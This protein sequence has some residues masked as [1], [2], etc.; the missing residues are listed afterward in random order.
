MKFS[1]KWLFMI[2]IG[3]ILFSSF[4]QSTQGVVF[5]TDFMPHLAEGNSEE[6]VLIYKYDTI[7]NNRIIFEELKSRRC[8][9]TPT[10]FQTA[11]SEDT[12][13]ISW[14]FTYEGRA[15]SSNKTDLI[16]FNSRSYVFIAAE[17]RT[18][19]NLS[20]FAT[21]SEDNGETWNDI[22]WVFNS[23][24]DI[25]YFIEFGAANLATDLF[26]AYSYKI[27]P[28]GSV[29]R[30]EILTIDP[31]SLEVETADVSTDYYGDDFDLLTHE[32]VIY[33]VSTYE[34]FFTER[35]VRVTSTTT[36]TSLPGS[37][38]YLMSPYNLVDFF[39]PAIVAWNDG[40]FIVAHDLIED[41]FDEI[42]N[43]TFTEHILWGA[44]V[45]NLADPN[46]ITYHN[47]VKEEAE[48]Y[49]RK[50]PSLSTYEGQ[51][52]L[53]FEL[54]E[55]TKLGGGRPEVAFSFSTNGNKWTD[56]FMGDFKIYFNPG[57]FFAIATVACFAIV[58]PVYVI[59]SKT[60]KK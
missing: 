50:S 23:S 13:I 26:I 35:S 7:S 28:A 46:T 8:R 14:D 18:S 11:E 34:D 31:I 38:A 22:K 2:L 1:K 20:F 12:L 24:I 56:N 19:G 21:F 5:Y 53:A 39:E 33:V 43:I 29:K 15:I 55:G 58:L 44:F 4:P 42:Q 57:I 51:I 10:E 47:V 52:F 54:T 25:N 59:T 48:G 36:G 32:N 45:G 17:D 30:T 41:I 16:Y 49:T 40:F 27:N 9:R 3:F 37:T 60:K 6:Y